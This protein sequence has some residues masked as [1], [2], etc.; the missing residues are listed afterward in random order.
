M[1]VTIIIFLL[2]NT[3]HLIAQNNERDEMKFYA[4]V[5]ITASETAHRITAANK[6][7]SMFRNYLEDPL[8]L[9]DS[10]QDFKWISQLLIDSTFRIFTWQV[11]DQKEFPSY[12]FIQFHNGKLIELIDAQDSDPDIEFMELSPAHWY[13]QLYYQ[14]LP[15]ERDGEQLYLLFGYDAYS[16]FNKHKIIDV[17]KIEDDRISF[18]KEIFKIPVEGSRDIVKYR[19]DFEYSADAVMSVR[20]NQEM[21]LIIFDHLQQVIGQMPGQGIT[22]VPDGTYEGFSYDGKYWNYIE[23]L[24]H[25]TMDEAP[26]PKPILDNKKKDILGRNN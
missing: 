5:M 16:V 18:G 7:H 14:I 24:F 20:Y 13:G 25:E 8:S 6:F 2:I 26:R 10:L 1:R 12:G 15:F 3:F 19:M 9:Q 4:D 21:Q 22:N 17:L 23:K 11:D